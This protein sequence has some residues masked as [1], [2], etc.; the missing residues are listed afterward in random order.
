MFIDRWVSLEDD[1]EYQTLVLATLRSLASVAK[2]QSNVPTSSSRMFYAW[3]AGG[4][5]AQSADAGS[6]GGPP[7]VF[8][9]PTP[10]ETPKVKKF[11]STIATS[12]RPDF[13]TCKTMKRRF[14]SGYGDW[15]TGQFSQ[16]P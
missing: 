15:I 11:D 14:F 3:N 8:E 4:H 10:K 12:N 13:V 9:L 16:V 7:P 2:I 6:R 1:A 5:R